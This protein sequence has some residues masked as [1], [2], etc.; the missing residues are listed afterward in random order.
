MFV[1][2]HSH[3]YDEAFVGEE[4]L[5]VKRAI[6]A[7]VT[8]MIL[9]DIDSVT[10]ESMFNLAARHPENLFP[11]IGLHPTSIDATS[12]MLISFF[13]ARNSAMCGI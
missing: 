12:S 1:D 9:P 3:L 2:T 8:R 10:R 6:E 13:V 11:C 7:G 4:D 5:A